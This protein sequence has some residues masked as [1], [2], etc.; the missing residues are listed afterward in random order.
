MFIPATILVVGLSLR[1]F[2]GLPLKF[3]SRTYVSLGPYFPCAHTER[4]DRFYHV[5]LFAV[6]FFHGGEASFF[7]AQRITFRLVRGTIPLGRWLS[8]P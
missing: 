1:N 8:E 3:L 5:T 6:K 4:G 7:A 2:R